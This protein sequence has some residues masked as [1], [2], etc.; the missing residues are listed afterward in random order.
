MKLT[1][2]G[3]I[4]SQKNNKQI[5]IN[6]RTGR[7]F[8]RSNDTV[9]AWQKDAKRQLQAQ[10]EGYKITDY[11]IEV[12]IVFYRPN[13]I[14]RDLDNVASGILDCM[15]ASEIIVD[16]DVN[17]VSMLTLSYGGVDKLNPRAEIF[18]ED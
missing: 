5:A 8:V 14:R 15:V 10:F 17:H 3:K 1:I 12:T 11:P 16:D 7:R 2:L 4:P 6:R 13:L 9:L 18:I